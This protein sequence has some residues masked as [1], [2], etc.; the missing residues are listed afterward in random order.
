MK[1]C[2]HDARKLLYQFAVFAKSAGK[3]TRGGA[4][5]RGLGR[6]PVAFDNI[7]L[8]APVYR[9]WPLR[10]DSSLACDILMQQAST[11]AELRLS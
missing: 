3:G 5:V 9:R 4:P 2:A 7:A 6:V 10:H 11:S 8:M 1:V